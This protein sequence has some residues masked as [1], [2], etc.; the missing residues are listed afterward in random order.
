MK[1]KSLRIG[2]TDSIVPALSQSL[3]L[4]GDLLKAD[5]SLVVDSML[6]EGI[7]IFRPGMD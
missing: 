1:R 3:F 4:H 2:D 7:K 5:S 6:S